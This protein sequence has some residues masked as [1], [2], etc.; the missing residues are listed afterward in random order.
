MLQRIEGSCL[1]LRVLFLSSLLPLIK[2]LLGPAPLDPAQGFIASRPCQIRLQRRAWIQVLPAV[3]EVAKEVLHEATSNV[4]SAD[5]AQTDI[6]HQRFVRAEERLKSVVI[7][8]ADSSDLLGFCRR[9]ALG[10]FV[11][12]RHVD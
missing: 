9:E 1:A 8:T 11:A 3:P 4:G 12:V 2:G 10:V 7:T 5:N 6:V